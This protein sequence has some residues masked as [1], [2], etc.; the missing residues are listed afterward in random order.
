VILEHPG[1]I[2]LYSA[3]ALSKRSRVS[4][5][6]V[7][8]LVKRL[9]YDHYREMQHEVRAAQNAGEP[10]Y[11]NTAPTTPTRED[12]ILRRHVEQDMMNLRHTFDAIHPAD[13]DEVSNRVITAHRVWIIGFRNSYFFASYIRRLIIQVRPDVTLLP[14]AGQVLMED[15]SSVGPKDLVIAVGFR[16]RPP[17]LHQLMEV[18]HDLE[19]PIAYITDRIVASTAK[20]VTWYFP[21]HVRG[22]SLF[23][24]YVGAVSLI[25]YLCTKVA[26][27]KGECG[28]DRL[29]RIEDLMELMQEIDTKN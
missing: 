7:T 15:L 18:L 5:A 28:R 21:C 26:E 22:I 12:E 9:G 25:N 23:D 4:K 8:R 16:R 6:A 27:H 20:L 1:N 14:Q 3:T 24:S 29:L 19:V 11:L 17:Q 13:L 2:L 10:V